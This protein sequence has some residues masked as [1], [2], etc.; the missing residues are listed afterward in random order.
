MKSAFNVGDL[1]K[2]IGLGGG[3]GLINQYGIV[4]DCTGRKNGTVFVRWISET[5]THSHYARSVKL[6]ARSK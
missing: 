6:M 4:I 5:R 1:V 2:F 3:T